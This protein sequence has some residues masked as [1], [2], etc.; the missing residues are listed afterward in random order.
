MIRDRARPE[1]KA[2]ALALGLDVFRAAMLPW[3]KLITGSDSC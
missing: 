2:E 3:L 1:L